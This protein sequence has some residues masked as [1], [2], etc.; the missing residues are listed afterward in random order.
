MGK[1]FF[2]F[3]V[4]AMSDSGCSGCYP[5]SNEDDNWDWSLYHEP[6]EPW[7]L[8]P[9]SPTASPRAIHEVVLISD[10]EE[11]VISDDES[12]VVVISVEG[13]DD[14]GVSFIHIL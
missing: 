11:I 6:S 10:Q 3:I 14:S 12:D 7:D 8:P 13:V 5:P 4:P 2:Y 9:Q 1:V